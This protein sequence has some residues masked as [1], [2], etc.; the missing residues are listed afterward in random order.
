LYFQDTILGGLIFGSRHQLLVN[1]ARDVGQDA[2]PIHQSHP[3]RRYSFASE[4]VPGEL[5]RAT[6]GK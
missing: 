4:T 5:R 1:H 2:H 6:T 3:R